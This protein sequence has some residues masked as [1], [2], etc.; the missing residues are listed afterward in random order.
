[1]QNKMIYD[2]NSVKF[3]WGKSNFINELI[4]NLCKKI[5]SYPT[6]NFLMSDCINC[7]DSVSNKNLL[8]FFKLM[9]NFNFYYDKNLEYFECLL[10]SVIDK[11][12]PEDNNYLV[13]KNNKFLSY[14]YILNDYYQY[15]LNSKDKFYFVDNN[16]IG[17]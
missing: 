7:N 5:I 12:I 6:I 11:N 2:N 17:F 10:T 4:T 8:R 14:V 13:K 9:V 1:M 15:Y 16:I 3:I